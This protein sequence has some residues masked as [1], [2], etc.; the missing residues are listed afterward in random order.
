MHLPFSLRFLLLAGAALVVASLRAAGPPEAEKA[1]AALAL[2][3]PELPS[4]FIASDST[5]AKSYNPGQVGWGEPFPHYFDT[6]KL[7]VINLARGGRSS[8]TFQTEGWWQ[9]L[10]DHA[11]PG[12]FVLIQFAHNDAT[13]I[14]SPK[15]RGT[16]RGLGDET[17][18]VD[19]AV[20]GERE[21]V[22]TFGW[23][24]RQ[25][26]A[27]AQERGLRVII[28]SPTIQNSWHDGQI[29]RDPVGYRAWLKVLAKEA[30]LPFVD[31]SGMAADDLQAMGPE[32]TRE[33]YQGKTHFQLGGAELHAQL[34]V[35]GLHRLPGQPLDG[36]LSKAGE[37]LVGMQ[38]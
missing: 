36:Y 27:S 14:D 3:N 18:E 38:P 11:K 7:N 20:T 1:A 5:A 35:I 23:Y 4:L 30:G 2:L 19:N 9:Q 21:T 13:E 31:L 24:V 25:M 26:I 28:V 12:D 6:D 33:L 8:R 29:A 34:V 22:H 37:I 10:L 16:I 32:Q 15:A 17:W